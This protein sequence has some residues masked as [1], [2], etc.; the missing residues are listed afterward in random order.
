MYSE[1]MTRWYVYLPA[2]M[3]LALTR[4]AARRGVT[5]A[6]LLRLAVEDILEDGSRPRALSKG[7][8]PLQVLEELE[9]IAS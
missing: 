1:A 5:M 3:M 6:S 4:L 9:E 7:E 2:S 8:A